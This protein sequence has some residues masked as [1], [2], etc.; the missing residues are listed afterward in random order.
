MTR[1]FRRGAIVALLLLAAVAMVAQLGSV[2]HLHAKPG[3]GFFNAEHDLT[4]LA[5]LAGHG[6]EV[7]AAPRLAPDVVAFAIAS[8]APAR[9]APRSARTSDS[10][11]PPTV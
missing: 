6:I 9:P 8:F 4:L 3:A 1:S 10:R 2:P 7:D 11:A 5:G